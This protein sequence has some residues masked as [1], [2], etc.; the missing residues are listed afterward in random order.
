VEVHPLDFEDPATLAQALGGVTV[1]FNTYWVR[2]HAAGFRQDEAIENTQRLFEAARLAGVRRVV[3]ISITNP[4]RESP[5]SYFAG[6]AQLEEDLQASGLSHGILRPAVLFGGRDVLINNMAWMLRR[7]PFFGIPGR[8]DFRLQPIHVDDLAQLALDVAERNDDV[9]VDAVGPETF[10]YRELV[11]VLGDAIGKPRRLVYLPRGVVLL[12]ARVMGLLL[13]DVVLTA[14]ELDALMDGL[15][16][17]GSP[18]TGERRLSEWARA[19]AERLGKRYASE[20]ARHRDR[21]RSYDEQ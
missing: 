17:T 13:G 2:F 21:S 8:G 3:H 9:V 1:L 18:A 20:V 10:T 6:K 7:F 16:Y 15:L 12:L 14:Q 4:S 5:Y 11:E 19:E